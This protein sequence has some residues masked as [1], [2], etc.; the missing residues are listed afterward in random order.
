MR[1]R[2]IKPGLFKNEVLGEADPVLTILFEGL[3]CMADR[4]GRLED[5]PAK[6]R[7]EVLPYRFSVDIEASLDWLARHQFIDRYE[8]DGVK[9]IQILEF[10]K[11][12]KP[13]KNEAPSTLAAKAV[14]RTRQG[15]KS[16]QPR[17]EAS[18]TEAIATRADSLIADSLIADSLNPPNPQ[19]G[20]P[21]SATNGQNGNGKHHR[22]ERPPD[23]AI[24]VWYELIASDGARPPRT[25]ELQAAIDAAGGWSRIAQRQQGVEDSIVRKA[26]C[27]AYHEITG[28]SA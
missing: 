18:T 11:H 22:R 19:G 10:K 12:Q 9:I 14:P 1:A 5:R 2:N 25:H 17:P 3:W 7:A 28:D 8:A 24:A 6:I 4:E 21:S 26:F 27:T 16:E 23:P 20:L 13:H 15:R